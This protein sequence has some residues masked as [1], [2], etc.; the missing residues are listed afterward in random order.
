MI[1]NSPTTT[2]NTTP[3]CKGI[4]NGAYSHSSSKSL[5]DRVERHLEPRPDF[6]TAEDVFYGDEKQHIRAPAGQIESEFT[7]DEQEGISKVETQC[8]D[9]HE[10]MPRKRGR[11]RKPTHSKGNS[12]SENTPNLV[13]HGVRRRSWGKWVS[14]IREPKKKSRIWLGSYPTPDMAAR[15][16]DV[17]ALCLKGT[18]ALLNFPDSASKLPRPRTTSPRDIQAAATV[19]ASHDFGSTSVQAAHQVCEIARHNP[20]KSEL[21]SMENVNQACI[22]SRTLPISQAHVHVEGD[23]I[24]DMPN[25]LAHMEEAMLFVSPHVQSNCPDHS[26]DQGG[27]FD[28]LW[29]YS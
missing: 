14:E 27:D 25:V 10:H 19:A 1:F 20:E 11:S 16:H 24:F 13:Y 7:I 29:N 15:A 6:G 4:C 21:S 9:S 26:S 5:C 2:N 23:L 22:S 8:R 3:P 28:I 18:S 12:T 17:A